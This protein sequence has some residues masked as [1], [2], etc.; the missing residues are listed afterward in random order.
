MADN[1]MPNAKKRKVCQK[2]TALQFMAVYLEL[3]YS[4]GTRGCKT[5]GHTQKVFDKLYVIPC[6]KTLKCEYFRDIFSKTKKLVLLHKQTTYIDLCHKVC[7]DCVQ[8]LVR[9]NSGSICCPVCIVKTEVDF[10]KDTQYLFNMAIS[11][12]C[13]IETLEEF[14]S[15]FRDFQDFL[16]TNSK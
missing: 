12:G 9:D 4:G 14:Q 11:K 2:V 5:A 3:V 8:K 1:M 6:Q 10:S 7:E 13:E 15:L 16:E